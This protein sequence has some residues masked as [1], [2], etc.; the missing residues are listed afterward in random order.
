[1][2]SL[3][4]LSVLVKVHGVMLS[5]LEEA[6]K[7]NWQELNRLDSERRSLLENDQNSV[8][9]GKRTSNEYDDWCKKILKLDAEINRTVIVAKQNLVKE[10]RGMNA[11]IN[12]KKSY[13]DA[14]SK[15]TT[16]YGQ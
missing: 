15:L 10:G 14:A 7:A 3:L 9:V 11:Q 1:M 13:E 6:E 2:K 12:A 4:A 8:I 16:T 5:M